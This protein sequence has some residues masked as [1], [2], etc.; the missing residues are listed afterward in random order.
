MHQACG[1]GRA[2]PEPW[3]SR[4]PNEDA[5]CPPT[6][7]NASFQ[8]ARPLRIAL[9][10]AGSLALQG[11]VIS[12][13]ADHRH[14]AFSDKDGD[15][16]SPW[17][18][19]TGVAAIARGFWHSHTGWLL[20]RDRTNARR[21]A[22]DL[23]AGRDVAAVDR[24]FIVPTVASLGLPALIGGLVT[25]SPWGAVTAL[26]RVGLVRVA[27]LHHVTW[28]INRSAIWSATAPSPCATAPPTCGGWPYCRSG[29]RGTTCTTP[30]RRARGTAYGAGR[31]TSPPGSS[32]PSRSSHSVRWPRPRRLEKL[33]R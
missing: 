6:C 10:V 32:G 28:S 33:A 31:W 14:H 19:G 26:F 18:F 15:P 9:A 5:A 1:T 20:R 23:L 25:W 21:F 30:I 16:H 13:M 27:L 12:W 17:L 3:P 4:P 8:A 24:L 2:G 7:T 11:G 22:P 29:S